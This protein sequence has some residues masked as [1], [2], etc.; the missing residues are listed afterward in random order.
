[1]VMSGLPYWTTDIGGFGGGN[2]SDSG[3]RELVVRW[4]QWGAFCPLFRLHGDRSGPTYPPAGE[5]PSK[6]CR[7]GSIF[8]K[9]GGTASNEVRNT[10]F[11]LIFPND[12]ARQTQITLQK[13]ERQIGFL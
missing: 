11:V 2:T 9:C 3:F 12:F 6:A 1:M 7:D 4:F 10:I 13:P 5:C 8:G